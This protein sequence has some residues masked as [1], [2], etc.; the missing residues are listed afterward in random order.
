M[1]VTLQLRGGFAGQTDS[2]KSVETEH[3]EADDATTLRRLV[4]AAKAESAPNRT[5][6]MRDKVTIEDGG[7]LVVLSPAAAESSKFPAFCA[8]VDWLDARA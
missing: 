6:G 5:D 2:P 7:Q 4:A 1:K 8:L 3:L